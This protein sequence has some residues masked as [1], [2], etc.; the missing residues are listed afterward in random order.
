MS[1]VAPLTMPAAPN[2]K[3]KTPKRREPSTGKITNP[4]MAAPAISNQGGSSSYSRQNNRADAR[5]APQTIQPTSAN[6]NT[7]N[8]K[9]KFRIPIAFLLA[10]PSI[11]ATGSF[12]IDMIVYGSRLEYGVAFGGAT[13]PVRG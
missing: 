9:G 5:H 10:L 7:N 8:N 3:R 12:V 1:S 6:H 13:Y 4:A 11:G 2:T